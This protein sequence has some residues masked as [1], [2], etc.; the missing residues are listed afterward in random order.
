MIIANKEENESAQIK[1]L[2]KD[3]PIWISD[4]QNLVDA[5]SMI[6]EIGIITDRKKEAKYLLSQINTG[7][8]NLAQSI[9]KSSKRVLY[10]IWK[11]PY[12]SVGSDT[13]IND[14]VLRCGWQNSTGN[15]QRYPELNSQDIIDLNPEIIFLSS[16]PYP[17]SSYHVS[18]LKML[19]PNSSVHL[20]DGE[21]FSWYGSRLNKAVDYFMKLAQEVNSAS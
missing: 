15:L 1:L 8:N 9:P 5:K 2:S 17:F 10:L 21:M 12:M 18:E 4:I 7:F 19:C 3:F 11:D 13:F 20:V 16:E 6:A 14:M